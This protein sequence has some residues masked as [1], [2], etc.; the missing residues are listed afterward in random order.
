MANVH[1]LFVESRWIGAEVSA[2]AEKE[3]APYLQEGHDK[4]IVME[5][6]KIVLEPTTAQAIA[7]VLHELATN[8]AKYGALSNAKGRI[9]LAWSRTGDGQLMLR[10]TELG[11]PRVNAPARKGFG[12]RLI[13]GTIS[14]LGGKVLFDWR[15]EGLVC[16]IV[17]PT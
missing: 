3:L 14:P 13:E 10:W 12:S 17:V 2:I 15:A 16:E 8:A 6:Q 11:G 7:V 5:G 4:R 1:S 9:G